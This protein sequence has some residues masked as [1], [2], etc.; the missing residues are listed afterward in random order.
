MRN[1]MK[2]DD[3]IDRFLAP[4]GRYHDPNIMKHYVVIDFYEFCLK[5]IA[6]KRLAAVYGI[7]NYFTIVFNDDFSMATISS[8]RNGFKVGIFY[9]CQYSNI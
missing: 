9:Y 1:G 2:Q 8:N 3:H 4:N 5:E 6:S 7:E